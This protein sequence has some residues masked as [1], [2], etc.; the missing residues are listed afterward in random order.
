MARHGY[1]QDYRGR[2]RVP[3]RSSP[4]TQRQRLWDAGI[5]RHSIED[6]WNILMR[7]L[8][9]GD[10]VV[11]TEM[12]VLASHV[13]DL[14]PRLFD[15]HNRR[16]HLYS[17]DDQGFAWRR[18]LGA[19]PGTPEYESCKLILE[20]LGDLS[21]FEL[22]Y[23]SP[24]ARQEPS[25]LPPVSRPRGRP[26]K[27]GP[28]QIDHLSQLR[29]QDGLGWAKLS[30]V[31]GVSATTVRRYLKGIPRGNARPLDPGPKQGDGTEEG[32]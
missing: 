11:V 7:R 4:D 1:V 20:V 22:Q 6:R 16:A 2:R 32:K 19:E 21:A 28:L 26:Q 29:W 27:L 9:P 23:A 15:L 30:D 31:A 8:V 25:T 17:L 14:V 24:S 10:Q 3:L 13:A 18:F 5:D 12:A